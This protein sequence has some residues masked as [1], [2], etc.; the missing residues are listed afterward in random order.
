MDTSIPAKKTFSWQVNAILAVTVVPILAAYIA[1]YTGWGVSENT[2]NQGHMLTPAQ[3]VAELLQN[4]TGDK[5]NFENNRQW[6]LLIPVTQECNEQCQ[7][8]LYL[9]RQVHIRLGDKA[10]RLERYA[11]NLS[12]SGGEQYLQTLAQDHPKLKHFSVTPQAWQAWLADTNAPTDLNT[13]HFVL[14]VDQ[15]GFAMMFYDQNND[16]NQLLK[17]IKRVLRYSPE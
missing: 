12:A 3:G 5:P 15:V 11:V 2:V 10:D 6:R 16:G 14:L 9:T 17:D 13:E 7:R 4:A 1:Y 8:D